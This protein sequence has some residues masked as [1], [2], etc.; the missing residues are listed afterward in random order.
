[1]FMKSYVSL[2]FYSLSLKIIP[3]ENNWSDL[4]TFTFIYIKG[5]I[6]SQ[7][8]KLKLWPFMPIEVPT[9]YL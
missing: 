9:L 1:M 2:K 7:D 5:D 6:S 8:L 3:P 4:W